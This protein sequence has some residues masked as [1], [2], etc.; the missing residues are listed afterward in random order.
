MSS[1][2]AL[3]RAR[4]A[5]TTWKVEQYFRAGTRQ[6]RPIWVS[7]LRLRPHT[8]RT[9][10]LRVHLAD[11]QMPVVGDATYGLRGSALAR[12]REDGL[13]FP[14]LSRFPRQALHAEKLKF[15]HPRS[16]KDME[17]RAPLC[18]DLEDLL[19]CL[20]ARERVGFAEKRQKGIDKE[21]AF[22]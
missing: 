10:Q 1:R 22:S 14:E 17:F 4:D 12:L 21:S 18:A 20:G 3:A 2:N 11:E 13:A 19:V 16:R 5:V 9:H 15:N 6:E 8:G 7:L